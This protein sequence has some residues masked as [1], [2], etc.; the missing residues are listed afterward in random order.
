MSL[1]GVGV[2]VADIRRF[3]RLLAMRGSGF[4]VRW[5]TDAEIAQCMAAAT[6]ATA[7]AM[8]YAAKEAVWKA[9]GPANGPGRCR[10]GGS[11]CSRTLPDLCRSASRAR[12]P[13]SRLS[14]ASPRCVSRPCPGP[15]W[16]SPPPSPTE[17]RMRGEHAR[18]WGGSSDLFVSVV[19]RGLFLRGWGGPPT[20]SLRVFSPAPGV[21]DGLRPPASPAASRSLTPGS[22]EK[23]FGW[24]SGRRPGC[25]AAEE[26]RSLTAKVG[27]DLGK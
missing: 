13:S 9:L 12:R 14:P 27:V 15:G 10:G 16:P 1:Q 24:L 19:C 22:G 4:A 20:L 23:R 5:F 21:K 17:P 18:R 2:D 3:A 25:D 26:G 8:R 11:P 6:P 7:F